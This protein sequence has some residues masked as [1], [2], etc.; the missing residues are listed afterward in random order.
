MLRCLKCKKYAYKTHKCPVLTLVPVTHECRTI[1]DMLF[2]L[3]IEPL[4][5]AHFTTP[6]TDSL[7]EHYITFCLELRKGYPTTILGDL[8]SQW[9]FH[10]ETISGD[11]TPL[12][13]LIL[14]YSETFVFDGELTVESRVQEIIKEFEGYLG[15]R[16]KQAIKSILMLMGS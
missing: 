13:L 10:T 4:S 11:H 8:P 1:A 7:Y 14:G 6:V 15:T 12:S 9:N 5:V 16:D 2:D 3:G